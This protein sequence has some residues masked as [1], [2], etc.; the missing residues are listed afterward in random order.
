MLPTVGLNSI[1][2]SGKYA[3][4]PAS[5]DPPITNEML[6]SIAPKKK[7]QKLTALRRGKATSLAPICSGTITFIRPIINGM[8][9]KRIIIKPCVVNTS[10]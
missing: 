3:D 1:L 8:A 2:A 6:S 4:Q 10:L 7:S 9:I 5:G